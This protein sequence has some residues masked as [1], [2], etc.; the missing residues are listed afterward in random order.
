MK[1]LVIDD[2]PVH[3]R[4]MIKHINW[5]KLGFDKVVGKHNAAEALRL[6][7]EEPFDL[8][9]TDINMPEISGLE[10]IRRINLFGKQPG[11][12][13]VSGYNE[14][15]YAQE[16]IRLGVCAYILKPVKPEE[17]E[18]N[19]L[20]LA[21]KKQWNIMERDSKVEFALLNDILEEPVTDGTE[22]KNLHPVIT[23][24]LVYIGKNYTRD[25][26]VQELAE[27]F[28]MNESY[29]SVLFKKEIG[30][31]LSS[32][33]QR[34]RINRAMELLKNSDMRISEIAYRVGYQ[35]PCYFT[36]QFKKVFQITPSEVRKTTYL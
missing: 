6:L 23:K 11:I 21:E 14:F 12:I 19:V 16:A 27:E 5:G 15:T 33:M 22:R 32:Y 17:V 18:E 31:N 9:L 25:I 10:L 4:G 8:V 29:L 3:V 2:E 30:I 1:V 24:I 35:N 7:Q 28:C 34:Y 20:L 13:I 36:E 26:T